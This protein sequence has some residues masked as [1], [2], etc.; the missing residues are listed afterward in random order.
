MTSD[1][2]EVSELEIAYRRRLGERI[3][4]LRKNRGWNQDTLAHL[5]GMHRAYPY[6][7]E[8]GL[9][10]IRLSTLLRLAQVFEMPLQQFL[11]IE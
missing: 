11:D 7:L 6:R 1:N 2:D 3:K 4:K 8:N 9:I 10:D 5:T